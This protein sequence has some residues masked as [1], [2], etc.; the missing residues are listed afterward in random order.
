MRARLYAV[1]PSLAV[2]SLKQNTSAYP[3]RVDI[4]KL[5]GDQL[6]P[7]NLDLVISIGVIHHIPDPDPVMSAAYAALKPGGQICFGSMDAKA[8]RFYLSIFEPLRT[9]TRR[10]PHY[11]LV[12]IRAHAEYLCGHIYFAGPGLTAPDAR[13]C[14]QYSR[15]L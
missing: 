13:L 15:S 9:V 7:L 10:L 8:M 12:P 11:L 2:K 1:E 6:P 3:D 5:R 4:L 14:H